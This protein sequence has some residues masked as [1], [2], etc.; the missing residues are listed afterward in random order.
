MVDYPALT[1]HQQRKLPALLKPAEAVAAQFADSSHRLWFCETNAG[2]LV[3]KVADKNTIRQSAFWQGVNRLFALNFPASLADTA[4][5]Q[6]FLSTRS[7]LQ[8]PLCLHASSSFVLCQ[9]LTGDTLQWA[10]LTPD[11]IQQLAEHIAG[12][13]LQQSENWGALIKPKFSPAQWASRLRQTLAYLAAHNEMEVPS[14]LLGNALKQAADI[15]PDR[16]VPVML[17]L[18]WDQFLTQDKKLSALVDLDA[19]VWAPL[20]LDLVLLECLLNKSQAQVFLQSYQQRQPLP[21]LTPVRTAYR[22]L[23][24]LMHILGEKDCQKWLAKPAHFQS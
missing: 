18:R 22:I 13:H 15:V 6:A 3:L 16:L 9:R 20:E 2:A 12:L 7:P 4:D 24:F 10:D 1:K 19:F 11:M 14:V 17:D 5:V 21:D 23:L 8:I